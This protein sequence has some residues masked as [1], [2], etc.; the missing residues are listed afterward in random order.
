MAIITKKTESCLYGNNNRLLMGIINLCNNQNNHH[1]IEISLKHNLYKILNNNGNHH[2]LNPSIYSITK[3]KDIKHWEIKGSSRHL[4]QSQL[5]ELTPA[6]KVDILSQINALR[7]SGADGLVQLGVSANPLQQRSSRMEAYFWDDALMDS[8]MIKA[9]TCDVTTPSNSTILSL[10]YIN[11]PSRI[12]IVDDTTL[13]KTL[14]GEILF[15][16]TQ[17]TIFTDALTEAL[18]AWEVDCTYLDYLNV[19]CLNTAPSI[20]NCDNCRRC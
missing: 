2:R 12:P 9:Q 15:N 6:D 20:Q 18:A 7:S 11:N 17:S 8:A 14:V 10:S 5:E 19:G 1:S 3:T 13:N 4:L 16:A